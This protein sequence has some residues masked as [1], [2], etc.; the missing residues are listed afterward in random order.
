MEGPQCDLFH[1]TPAIT[2]QND[3]L[4]ARRPNQKKVEITKNENTK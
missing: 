2:L 4:R 3:S 1:P